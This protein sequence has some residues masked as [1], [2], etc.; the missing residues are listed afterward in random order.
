MT[1]QTQVTNSPAAPGGGNRM[2]IIGG[3]AAL[4]LIAVVVIG[5]IFLIP[6]L[7]GAD[8]NAIASVMPP[9]TSLLVEVNALNLANED[10]QRVARAFE[11]VLDESDVDF[12]ADDPASALEQLDDQMDEATGMTITDD[13]L[14]WIGPNLGIGLL[15]L[16]V[17]AIDNNEIPQIIF[18][19]TIREIEP[20]DIFIE[21]LIDVIEEESG[22]RVDEVEYGGALVFEID[23]D[24]EDERIAFGRSD[25]IFFIA[26]NIDTLEEAIDAQNGESLAG[27]EE[28]QDTIASLSGD[29]AVTVYMS[30]DS[31]EEFANAAEDSPDFEGFDADVIKDLELKG[32]GMAGMITAE[33]IRLDFVSSY[34]SLSEEQQEMLDAQTD[35]IKTADFLPEST[36]LFLVG[37]RL[38]LT[39]QTAVD[40]LASSGVN[41][42]DFDEAMDM[43]DDTFGFNPND[44]LM[45]L[46]NGEYSIAIIDSDEGLL[47]EE[48][49]TDL[50]AVIMIGGSDSEELTNL[51]EDFTDGL[52]DQDL[53]V[54]DSGNDDVTV[55]EIE[56]PGGDLVGAYGVSEDYLIAATS[57]ESIENLFNGEANLADS[58][59]FSN[60]WDA[61]PRGTI[62]VM[63]IDLDGL[64]AALE[65]VDPTMKDVV[66]VNPV[67]AFALGTNNDNNTTLTTMI[68]FVAGE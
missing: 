32:V 36:Y 22:N 37:Q 11:D 53:S 51:A 59:K 61:F 8:E 34:N 35:N 25:M 58:D 65:D 5:A 24:F 7:F 55:Y 9:S 66:D 47:A 10:A 28:Y 43:F 54:D 62:P 48:F 60:A 26:T 27:V 21:D 67:Y 30:G 41:E 13:V 57:G 15:E 40:A 52:E 44:D 17:E 56:D 4:A 38:D 49:E 23:S 45:P 50:G 3:I 16:D 39:W 68:F 29:R 63:Y 46:L 42:D 2:L 14:P 1:E 12:N 31:I 18:A 19:A 64:F 20:A 33:G 6:R